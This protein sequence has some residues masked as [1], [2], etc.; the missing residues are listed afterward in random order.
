MHMSLGDLPYKDHKLVLKKE[1]GNRGPEYHEVNQGYHYIK[2]YT[3]HTH[4]E[5]VIVLSC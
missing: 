1:W 4:A 3:G 2:G 5:Q